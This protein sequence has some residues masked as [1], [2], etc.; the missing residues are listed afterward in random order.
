MMS[1]KNSRTT[2]F[3]LIELLVVVAII[4]IL[5]ALVGPTLAK[6]RESGRRVS[7]QS[8][9]R[10][11][12]KGMSMYAND[13]KDLVM[14]PN[15]DFPGDTVPGWLYTPPAPPTDAKW[16]IDVL[17]TGALWQ[18]VQG[19]SVYRCPT[20]KDEGSWLQAAK[21]TSYLWNGALVG[22]PDYPSQTRSYTIDRLRPDAIFAF[23]YNG[24]TWSD[25]AA[26]PDEFLGTRHD[27][28]AVVAGLDGSSSWLGEPDAMKMLY[29]P[30]PNRL[31]C[32][33]GHPTGG[34]R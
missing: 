20:D 11:M 1:F 13:N 19:P 3:T 22:Y 2:G 12:S 7:C 33:P 9:L 14:R 6:A 27:H 24:K 21:L 31:W 10:Q 23:E 18:Y 15:W 30:E 8:N 25:G 29:S 16:T 4:G 34:P 5:M 26:R 28:G 32:M 17:E